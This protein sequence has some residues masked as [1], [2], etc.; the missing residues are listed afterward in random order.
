MAM[1]KSIDL[2][3]VGKDYEIIIRKNSGNFVDSLNDCW[4]TS[5]GEFLIFVHDDMII[6][7]SLWLDKF[8]IPNCFMT[9][10]MTRFHLTN[11]EIPSWSPHCM[12]RSVLEKVG[13]LDE[14]FKIG[15][16]WED[17]DYIYR[18]KKENIPIEVVNIKFKHLGGVSNQVY[19]PKVYELM[20]MNEE[21]F[22]KKW[23]T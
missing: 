1:L 15:L 23:N 18:M 19:R 6:E 11:E 8:S 9:T 3:S 5:S 7:D 12:H 22:R 20:K 16:C 21:I 13:Y 14:S 4:K 17:N 2:N 10:S